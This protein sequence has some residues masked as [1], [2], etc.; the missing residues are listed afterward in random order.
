MTEQELYLSACPHTPSKCM[1]GFKCPFHG[2]DL[3]CHVA[4]DF[5]NDL[6]R[7]Q[8]FFAYH[9][10]APWSISSAIKEGSN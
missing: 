2:D 1:G 9:S 3:Q 4:D 10:G 8:T 5:K 7:S 6:N